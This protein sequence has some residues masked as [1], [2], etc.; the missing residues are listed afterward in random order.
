MHKI[1]LSLALFL[2]FV[3]PTSI[4]AACD[5]LLDSD[6]DGF[7]DCADACPTDPYNSVL[8]PCACGQL[9]LD[10]NQ[11]GTPECFDECVEDPT[12][13]DLGY[14]SCPLFD[15]V[16]E[17]L[18]IVLPCSAPTLRPGTRITEPPGVVIVTDATTGIVTVNFFF[19]K[20]S[21]ARQSITRLA[22]AKTAKDNSEFVFEITLPASSSKLTKRYQLVVEPQ[23][24]GAQVVK[25]LS[26]RNEY[27]LTG[28]APGGYSAKYRGLGL[29]RNNKVVFK[30]RFSP[31]KTFTV[32]G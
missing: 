17:L 1:L 23:F 24:S 25:K 20:F 31:A 3:F 2:A 7:D 10:L 16:K 32:P 4:F 6:S 15:A 8:G 30:T 12:K 26:K 19:Q 5:P 11:D 14:C 22:P 13:P 18:G 28:L 21:G 27:A 29:D 9:E